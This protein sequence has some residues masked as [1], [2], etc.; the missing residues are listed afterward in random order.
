[1]H[2]TVYLRIDRRTERR[3]MKQLV[4]MKAAMSMFSLSR[5]TLNDW[6]EK[7]LITDYRTPGGHRRID[8]SEIEGLLRKDNEN[9]EHA[10]E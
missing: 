1:M 7:G 5:A 4:R 2:K 6:V 8:P 3:M 10:A 9:G